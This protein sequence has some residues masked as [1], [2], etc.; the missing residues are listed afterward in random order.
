MAY[1]Y[2]KNNQGYGQPQ[3][4]YQQQQGGYQQQQGGYQQQT[5]PPP[6]VT[7][8]EFINERLDIYLMF[9]EAIKARG[10]DPTDF[11]FS[12]GGWTTSF[13]MTRKGK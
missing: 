5:P 7:P 2:R 11:A 4:G 9:T 10:L 8:E 13:A 6:P 3:G 12:L 1:S